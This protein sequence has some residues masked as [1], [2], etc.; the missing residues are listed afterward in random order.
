[1]QI[2][3]SDIFDACARVVIGTEKKT[4]VKDNKA[5]GKG[6]ETKPEP[7]PTPPQGRGCI[8]Q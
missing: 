2:N 3:V 5:K 8:L 7:E 6:K 1:M 4:N